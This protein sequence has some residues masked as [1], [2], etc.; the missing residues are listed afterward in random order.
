MATT[1]L[2]VICDPSAP[3]P[4]KRQVQKVFGLT[5]PVSRPEDTTR[6][7][8]M[9]QSR[10]K[11]KLVWMLNVLGETEIA[12]EID[13]QRQDELKLWWAQHKEAIREILKSKENFPYYI[14]FRW[15]A[16]I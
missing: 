8:R 3:Q 10:G 2:F 4:L 12:S 1:R 6:L 7:Y 15:G 16:N 13:K 14:A 5:S 9:P 11:T